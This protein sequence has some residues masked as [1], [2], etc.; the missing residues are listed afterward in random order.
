MTRRPR[1][2]RSDDT[3][4]DFRIATAAA[5]A[6]RVAI[7]LAGGREVCFVCAV[8]PDGK[9]SAARAV[10]RGTAGQVLALPGVAQ[11]GEMLV[12]NHP[13]GWLEPSDAD[14][15]I[16]A[17]LHDDGIGF[18]IIDNDVTDL[19]VVTEVP[20]VAAKVLVPAS[21]IERDFGP[22]GPLARGF[23]AYETRDGQR[24]MAT[25]IARTYADGGVALLEAGTGVGKSM[26]YLVP[27]LR[28]A[29][30]NKE[31][32]VVSTNTIT[33]Q[34]QLVGK[35]LPLL[36]DLLS[37][38]PVRFALLKGW[39]NYLCLSRL[40]QA[41]AASASLFEAPQRDELA[42]LAE[43]ANATR[44]GSLSDLPTPPRPDVWDEVAAEGD[45][46]T[47]LK[48]SRFDECFVFKARRIAATADVVVVNHSLLLADIA[49]RRASQ[50]WAE[51]AVLPAYSH[52]VVDEGHHLEDAAAN[53]LGSSVS[54]RAVSKLLNRLERRGGREAKGLLPTLETRLMARGDLLSVASLD[55]LRAR[56]R[57]ALE[58]ARGDAAQLFDRIAQWL[59]SSNVATVRLTPD[60]HNE[61]VW[62]DGLQVALQHLM[63]T[64][65]SIGENLR[66]IR[67][68][69]E[70][71]DER[72]E[73]L[74][75]LLQELRGVG[76]RTSSQL[77]ALRA[78]L[79]P[80]DDAAG[81]VRWAELRG[82]ADGGPVRGNSTPTVLLYSVPLD[83][84]P[85]LRDDLFGRLSSTVVTS[86]TLTA[87][88]NFNF[89]LGRLGLDAVEANVET[90]QFPSPFDYLTNALLVVPSDTPAPN[91][92]PAGHQR[93]VVGHV[94][95][96]AAAS[97]GG[98]FVLATSHRDVRALA[99]ALRP[100]AIASGW[101]LLV[102][103]EDGRD[104]LLRRFRESGRAILVGT[105]TFW[106]G[107]DVPGRALRGLVITKLPF[108]VPSEP[109]VAAQCDAIEARGGDPFMEYMLPHATLRLKQGVGRLIRTATDRGVIVLDDV[110]VVTK[111]YGRD[112][113]DALPPATRVLTPW[114]TAERRII[115]FYAAQ[116]AEPCST[117][118]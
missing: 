90:A 99:A 50:N 6:M 28:W 76:S 98:L 96:L 61:A 36:A 7:R 41:Q 35:D 117:V 24:D 60:L 78:T 49:V 89:L 25:T 43:W 81:Y 52:L 74:L 82:R 64:L 38:Q 75:S 97:D 4:P 40:T 111:R 13:S 37:D 48:C 47:R 53:H 116:A 83:L 55:L 23:G 57:P 63:Q 56:L 87:D 14:L 100:A 106:E 3:P 18:G 93:S 73:A 71:E 59:Q 101:P 102:H 19:Y 107:V 112:L 72:D 94:L 27:A 68:R 109:M 30:A 8:D 104:T 69:L 88:A 51:A 9:V 110:R 32:T 16:A 17:K 118:S 86:A 105:A 79:D 29:A 115:D 15:G 66:L 21:A 67:E 95:D 22:D 11:R 46:C 5:A 34:E 103:G 65:E 10:A 54:N 2:A 84:A 1:V 80:P 33:L 26:A 45:L 85:I 70:T 92:D 20:R 44:D 108:R 58:H 114:A 77:D 62:R 113:L 42:M 31:R 39:R 12:H 91:V